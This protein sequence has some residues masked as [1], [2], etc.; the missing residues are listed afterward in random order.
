M[1]LS[2]IVTMA[3][4]TG[5][6]A[7][8]CKFLGTPIIALAVGTIFAVIQLC[9]AKKIDEF[10][11][12]VNDTLKT[13]GPILFITAAGGVL[14]KVI[15]SSDM[16]NYISEHATVLS[17]MGI[18]FP[19]LLSAILKSAQESSTVASLVMGIAAIIEIAILSLFIH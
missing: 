7:S 16:V 14:G 11:D 9:G 5:T 18:F 19:F 13:V 2:S 17:A 4:V 1:A 6:G 15:A 12:I 10:Y 8:I 3:K